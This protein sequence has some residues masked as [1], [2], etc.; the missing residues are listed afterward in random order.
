MAVGTGLNYFR[1]F[2]ILCSLVEKRP[3]VTLAN[4]RQVFQQGEYLLTVT[5]LIISPIILVSS[6]DLRWKRDLSGFYVLLAGLDINLAIRDLMKD[7][8]TASM[9]TWTEVVASSL[10]GFVKVM[11]R[12]H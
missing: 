5:I 10:I 11:N 6:D 1:M 9:I 4:W 7:R 3:K 12:A 8:K 2:A